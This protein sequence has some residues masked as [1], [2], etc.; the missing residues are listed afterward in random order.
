MPDR[1]PGVPMTRL[2]EAE[3]RSMRAAED[4]RFLQ[5]MN[6]RGRQP[7]DLEGA[8]RSEN[9]EDRRAER[10]PAARINLLR[11]FGVSGPT[12]MWN[13]L[14]DPYVGPQIGD[15]SRQAGYEDLIRQDP[16]RTGLDSL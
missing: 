9:V 10:L 14:V 11:L 4:A 6:V 13:T 16:R 7:Y 12:S 8:R 2:T 3:V 15:L 5:A 1:L